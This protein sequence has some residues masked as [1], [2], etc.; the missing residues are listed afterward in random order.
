MTDFATSIAIAGDIFKALQGF[1]FL[2]L[3]LILVG[4]LLYY[5]KKLTLFPIAAIILER[6][7]NNLIMKTDR[8]GRVRIDG[9]WKYK[10]RKSKETI[11]NPD[12]DWIVS[13]TYTPTNFFEK[14]A[15]MVSSPVGFAYFYKYGSQQYKPVDIKLNDITSSD[16]KNFKTVFRPI[17]NEKGE[18]VYI[19]KIMQI[20]PKK[21]V[22]PEFDVIDWDNMNFIVQEHAASDERR[23]KKDDFMKKVL[24]PMVT[25]AVAAIVLIIA[26][27]FAVQLVQFGAGSVGS[28]A[29][30]AQAEV[31]A[32]IPVIGGMM[33]S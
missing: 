20:S 11:P 18:K 15:K 9:I 24:I 27:Y 25:I 17:L 22:V 4:G 32:G 19:K 23:K 3:P 16:K 28:A 12:Y 6:R 26:M 8:I 30:V 31:G 7:D 5:K 21:M 1:F 2:V 29:P 10:F 13:G 14:I 33:P